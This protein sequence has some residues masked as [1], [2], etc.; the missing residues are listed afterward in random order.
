MSTDAGHS[1]PSDALLSRSPLRPPNVS[2]SPSI[3][4]SHPGGA[5]TSGSHSPH[6]TSPTTGR[7]GSRFTT[8]TPIRTGDRTALNSPSS[9]ITHS[10]IS[11]GRRTDSSEV[12]PIQYLF[13]SLLSL[14]L[15]LSLSLSLS[16]CLSLQ[17]SSSGSDSEVPLLKRPHVPHHRKVK[18]RTSLS[19]LLENAH[20]GT[21]Q[22]TKPVAHSSTTPSSLLRSYSAYTP[23]SSSIPTQRLPGDSGVVPDMTSQMML[24]YPSPYHPAMVHSPYLHDSGLAAVHSGYGGHSLFYP[25]RW[26]HSPVTDHLQRTGQIQSVPPWFICSDK[27]SDGKVFL[28]FYHIAWKMLCCTYHSG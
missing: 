26:G 2:F 18:A 1:S 11:A 22:H 10:P 12:C 25:S 23:S 3:F 9:F 13:F 14:F 19:P 4:L 7:E 27:K 28:R 6:H 17:Y 15:S 16:L 5:C 21:A 8:S 24:S 20:S